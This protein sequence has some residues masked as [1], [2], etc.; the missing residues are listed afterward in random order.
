[1][2]RPLN[3]NVII[4]K[5]SDVEKNKYGILLAP[6]IEERERNDIGEVIS[7]ADSVFDVE[8]GDTVIYSKYAG[9]TLKENG[10]DYLIISIDDILAVKE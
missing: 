3:N 1:M 6:T 10:E 2:F 8:I 7:V 4:K 9:S 5:I